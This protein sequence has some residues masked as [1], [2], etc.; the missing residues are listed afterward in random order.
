MAGG[1]VLRTDKLQEEPCLLTSLGKPMTPSEDSA[2]PFPGKAPRGER[3]AV[4]LFRQSSGFLWF[5]ALA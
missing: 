5:L 1:G 4:A 3:L 2:T